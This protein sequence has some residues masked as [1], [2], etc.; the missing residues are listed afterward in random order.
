[1]QCAHRPEQIQLYLDLEDISFADSAGIALL[2]E[3]RDQGVALSRVSP[4]LT[5]LFKNDSSPDGS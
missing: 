5:E 4:F 1:M 3:L 2:K